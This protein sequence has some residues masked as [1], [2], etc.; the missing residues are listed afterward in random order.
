MNTK[1]VIIA[2]LVIVMLLLLVR[3]YNL[4]YPMSY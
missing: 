2:A 1:N 4:M 3:N